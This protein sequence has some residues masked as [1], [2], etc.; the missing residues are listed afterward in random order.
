MEEIEILRR[1]A[2]ALRAEADALANAYRRA[3]GLRFFLVFFPVPFVVVLFRLQV[4]SWT[5]FLYGGAYV[6][7]SA[8]LYIWDSKASD[9]CDAAERSATAAERAA[10][11]SDA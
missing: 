6:G 4:E 7:F 11:V 1:R 8:L 10:I 5:Y 3:T 9:K 2:S